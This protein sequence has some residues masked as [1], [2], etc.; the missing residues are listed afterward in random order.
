[1]RCV[2]CQIES[3]FTGQIMQHLHYQ[4]CGGAFALRVQG[5]PAGG[6]GL[7][8]S[9]GTENGSLGLFDS[10]SVNKGPAR[11]ST[12]R[13]KLPWQVPPLQN[14]I[15]RESFSFSL[16]VSCSL[17]L[18]VPL[19]LALLLHNTGLSL[20]TCFL[21]RFYFAPCSFYHIH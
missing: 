8:V 15:M 17:S 13:G 16:S 18:S 6:P 3:S 10:Q 2:S 7:S 14:G 20:C 5:K 4:I 12:N 1:M 21:P 19:S 9:A 11:S